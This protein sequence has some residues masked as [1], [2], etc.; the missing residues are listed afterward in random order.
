MFFN[1]DFEWDYNKNELNKQKH[2]ISFEAAIHI[3]GNI[4]L[5]SPSRGEHGEDRILAIGILETKEIVVV[6]TD[7]SERKRIISAR[8]AREN[9]RQAYKRFVER[10]NEQSSVEKVS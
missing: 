8:R 7:R 2:N 5:E 9:E 3:F 1:N 6:Y 4:T 10:L